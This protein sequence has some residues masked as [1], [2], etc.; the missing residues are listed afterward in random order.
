VCWL[1]AAALFAHDS[2]TLGVHVMAGLGDDDVV[3]RG[4]VDGLR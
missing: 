1:L 3:L 2:A 4:G